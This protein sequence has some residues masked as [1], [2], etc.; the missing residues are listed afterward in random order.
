MQRIDTTHINLFTTGQC[1]N[2]CWYCIED[3]P[4]KTTRPHMDTKTFLNVI[5]FIKKQGNDKVYFHFYGGEPLLH[6]N[7]WGMVDILRYEFDNIR[8][9]ISTNLNHKYDVV[10]KIPS[11]FDVVVSMHN[12]EIVDYTDWLSNVLCVD[13]QCNIQEVAL[14]TQSTNLHEM[15]GLYE[16]W[17]DDLPLTIY[18]IDQYKNNIELLNA[19]NMSSVPVKVH[20]EDNCGSNGCMCSAG[21]DIDVLGNVTKCSAYKDNILMNVNDTINMLPKWGICPDVSECPCDNEFEKRT[22]RR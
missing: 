7:I 18:P 4:A 5:E 16:L 20:V 10:A 1:N 12:E 2:K 13:Y 11:D 19:I 21:W 15:V 14:M 22:L 6:P 9:K 8:F 3:C 17:C